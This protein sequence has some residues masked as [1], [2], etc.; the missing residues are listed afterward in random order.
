MT[1]S[2][3]ATTSPTHLMP[4]PTSVPRRVLVWAAMTASALMLVACASQKPVEQKDRYRETGLASY[5]AHRFHGRRTASGE[6]Y[7]EDRLTAA[8]R[9]LPFGTRLKVTNLTNGREV[10]VKV[11]DRGP[12]VQGR[13]I[14]LSYAAAQELKMIRPGV[15]KVAVEEID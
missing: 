1:T 12:F 8:H 5:Y 10:H 6:T 11:N 7:L 13:I 2:G 14:D 15:V 4:K 3:C 9:W